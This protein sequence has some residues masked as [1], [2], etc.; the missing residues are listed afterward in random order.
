MTQAVWLALFLPMRPFKCVDPPLREGVSLH[1]Y[2]FVN[3]WLDKDRLRRYNQKKTLKA[4]Y[5]KVR[6][7]A[8]RLI[9]KLRSIERRL[10]VRTYTRD[11]LYWCEDLLRDKRLKLVEKRGR[12]ERGETDEQPAGRDDV[13]GAG[14]MFSSGDDILLLAD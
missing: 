14:T 8:R 1:G 5:F 4:E 7:E 10:R 9:K 11:R 6:A 2:W 12:N 3:T 13:D